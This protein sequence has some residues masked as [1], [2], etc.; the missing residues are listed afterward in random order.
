M[1]HAYS[2]AT[3]LVFAPGTLHE[4]LRNDTYE[5]LRSR[6]SYAIICEYLRS[7][8][9]GS[10][11]AIDGPS[12]GGKTS[13]ATAFTTFYE[14]R[15]IPV[16]FIPL[17]YFLTDRE[18]RKG[19]NQAI[20]EGFMDI[21]NYSAA[22]WEQ[23]RYHET[24]LSIRGI[25]AYTSA[26]HHLTLPDVYDRATGMKDSVQSIT[27]R[28]GSII[29]TEGVGIHMYHEKLFDMNI[30]VDVHDEDILLERVLAREHQ[31]P[32]GV[33]QLSDEFLQMRYEVVDAPHTDYLRTYTSPADF[34]ID[35]SD[36]DR[37]L[38]YRR[39]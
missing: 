2:T 35:T 27:I 14:S 13:L 24:L 19:I 29:L 31:K 25:T 34:V 28:P 7:A 39:R 26:P 37:M 18:T 33:P 4:Y 30:R 21:A 12:N 22:A 17:D 11:V 16:V 15:G 6:S 9:P 32:A 20:S 5:V 38:L 1:K 36:F 23:A 3:P 10:I 8:T